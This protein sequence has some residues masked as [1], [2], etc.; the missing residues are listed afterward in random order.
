M[1]KNRIFAAL[2][3][4]ALMLAFTASA[5][6]LQWSFGTGTVIDPGS[7]SN[8]SSTNSSNTNSASYVSNS[9]VL[10]SGGDCHVR[11]QPNL[12]G[13]K[14]GVLYNGQTANCL[15]GQSTDNRGVV[16]Y[17]INFN[18]MSGWVS[19]R[20][21]K[22][23]GVLTSSQVTISGGQC[24]MRLL[25]NLNAEI[26][27][28][29]EEGTS[30]T[31]LNQSSVDDRGVAWYYVDYRGETGW[32]SSRY[33]KF[34]GYS[35]SSSYSYVKATSHKVNLRDVPN[36]NGEDIGTMD[37]GETATYLGKTSTDSRGIDWYYVRF[38]G[39]TGWVSSRYS[40]LY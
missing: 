23:N 27:A 15:G 8:N 5:S 10:I 3:A 13:A 20:Y 37:K 19:S 18:G 22:L 28:I 35:T 38:N 24:N 40:K 9:Y 16:W 6:S 1:K 2:L 14:L 21:A 12:N 30:A 34:G 11:Q 29:L 25:P 4:L 33:A 17:E 39:K 32:V 31:Y 7:G 36:L 26:V